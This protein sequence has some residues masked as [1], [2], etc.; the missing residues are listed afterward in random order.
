LILAPDHTYTAK[1]LGDDYT[2]GEPEYGRARGRW[3]LQ[4]DTLHILPTYESKE[5]KRDLPS[6]KL[7]RQHG[8]LILVPVHRLPLASDF[9]LNPY[10]FFERRD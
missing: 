3:R 4:G 2:Y 9:H 1:W 7:V 6:M 8:K 10:M 5:I